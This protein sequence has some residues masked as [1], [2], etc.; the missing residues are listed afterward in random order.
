M[1]IKNAEF[2]TSY[3]LQ[4]QLPKGTKKEIVMSGRS[5]VGKSSLI[6]KVCNRKSLART[7][8]QPGKTVTVNFY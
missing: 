4:A 7:S 3:G 5:N 2:V 6:N 1:I 8:S